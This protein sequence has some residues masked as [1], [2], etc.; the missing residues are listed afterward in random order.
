MIAPATVLVM[1]APS[2]AAPA[3]LVVRTQTRARSLRVASRSAAA[4]F[5]KNHGG[6]CG[7]AN[8]LPS[9]DLLPAAYLAR[10]GLAP[11][12]ASSMVGGVTNL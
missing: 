7:L 12:G 8:P 11:N 6:D 5:P 2:V 3:A 1:L 9:R 4:R 10:D